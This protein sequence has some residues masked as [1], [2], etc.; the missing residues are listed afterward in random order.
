LFLLTRYI[1]SRKSENREETLRE[2]RQIL[3]AVKANDAA[4]V[5]SLLYDHYNKSLDA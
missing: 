5:Q 4:R 2:H 1:H 3:D